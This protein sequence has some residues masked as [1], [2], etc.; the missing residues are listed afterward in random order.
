[1]SR[2]RIL[3]LDGGGIRG[4]L[5]VLLLERLEEDCPGF[6]EQFDLFAGTSIGS[7]IALALAAGKSPTEVR[8]LFEHYGRYIFHDSLIDN[9]RDM[10][11]A[12]GAKYGNKHLKKTLTSFFGSNQLADLQKRVLVTSFDLDHTPEDED[13]Q[14]MWKAKFFHNYPGEGSDACEFV[15]NVAMRSSAAPFYF[16]SYQ[17][18]VDG[19][20]V[21]NNPAMCALT[22]ALDTAVTHLE[23][24]VLLSLGTGLNPR[25]ISDKDTDWGWIK[26]MIQFNPLHRHWYALPLVYM[27]WEGGVNLANYQCRQLIHERFHRLDPMLTKL[28]DIDEVRRMPLLKRCALEADLTETGIWLREQFE[29]VEE[30]TA[31]PA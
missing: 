8:E 25:Y 19:F 27:M 11:F 4:Y 2:Y 22:Q 7:I 31:V 16:P 9:V 13:E 12:F 30:L 18:Y 1:M 26:W 5:T 15:V 20:V 24:I 6:L 14:R 3:S 17:G 10:G 29:I 28:V 21:A 23:D